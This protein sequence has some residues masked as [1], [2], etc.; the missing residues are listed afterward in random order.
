MKINV[1]APVD[2]EIGKI[3]DLKDGVF[4]EKMLGDGFYIRAKKTQKHFFA[5]VE[6]GKVSLIT[7]T[8]HAFFFEINPQISVLM[9]I[10]LDTVKLEGKPFTQKVNVLD[11]ISTSTNIVDVDIDYIN[12]SGLDHVCPITLNVD[13]SSLGTFEFKMVAKLKNVKQG[14]LVGWF[15]TVENS[16]VSKEVDT[17]T[18]AKSFFLKDGKYDK[19][20]KS[21]NKLVGTK[22]NYS[23]VYN[24]MTRLRFKIQNKNI[25]KI[26]E[27]K[28]IAEVRGIVWNGN[29]LQ[30]I[31]G[32]DVYK[33]KEAVEKNNQI[34]LG[35]FELQAKQ[36][37]S[38]GKA[39]MAMFAG[40]MT[41]MIPLFIGTGII[42]AIIGL[43]QLGP[44]PMI[45][46]ADFFPSENGAPAILEL[47]I[48]WGI[49][50]VI[51]KA[52][53]A[54]MGVAI[55]VSASKYFK[56]DMVFGAGIG[57][58]I[59]APMMFSNGGP[60]SIGEEWVLFDFG[61]IVTPTEDNIALAAVANKISKWTVTSAGI[62]IFAVI[63]IIYLAAVVDR[64]V[65]SWVHPLLELTI[66]PLIVVLV[67][68]GIG[69]FLFIP[70]WNIFEGMFGTAMYYISQ[71][72][73]GIGV[74]LFASIYQL[75][76]VFGIHIAIAMIAQIQSLTAYGYGDFMFAISIAVWAQVGALI[77]VILMTKN[78]K[79]KRQAIGLIP[80]GVLGVT[81]PILYGI[82]LPK[83]RPLI[84]G[85]IAA[86]VAAAFAGIMGVTTRVST[87]L[88]IFEVI[89][90]FQLSPLDPT[91][92]LGILTGQLSTTM[93][94]IW[95]IVACL[96]SVGGALL[97]CMLM[98]KERKTEKQGI[99]IITS[100]IIKLLSLNNP[101]LKQSLIEKAKEL[102]APLTKEEIEFIKAQEKIIQELNKL[103]SAKEA[104]NTKE[105]SIKEKLMSKG[106]EL[107]K[108]EKESNIIKAEN[109]MNKL[110]AINN[111]A[112]R[113]EFDRLIKDKKASLDTEKM[114]KLI[115]SKMKMI[116][117]WIADVE[118]IS[119]SEILKSEKLL[120]NFRNALDV[121]RISYGINEEL[122]EM[123]LSENINQLKNENKTA[124]QLARA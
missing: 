36:K 19:L 65:R 100:K 89:G 123:N 71:L 120:N 76:V 41:K 25:V 114:N 97:L 112:K 121:M 78:A 67:S 81:E 1:Y 51:G 55:A 44:M 63:A 50:F 3:E 103:Q 54:S 58:I 116:N 21:I 106:A 15:E 73:F 34:A 45:S 91:G 6:S 57:I 22:G 111:D 94:G 7:E 101:E 118:K 104:L 110:N 8:K 93:N 29:E 24:C 66:R 96:I 30:I 18:D 90:Y 72:P 122:P 31:I 9:H 47:G 20:A 2:G 33:L 88:G 95:Y 26:D 32:Q 75:S 69:M 87:G 115:A 28:A 84:A 12:Q 92:E 10:G 37:L 56:L 39:F 61:D 27:I 53:M 13:D 109:I 4:S 38:P 83:K 102:D 105:F 108:S 64:W 62:K 42:Q 14:E 49:L 40:I 17:K 124:K 5:P 117:K 46:F 113:A 85:S 68:C 79:L 99:S 98:Y 77:G 43:L 16:K 60:S 119:S 23:D 70:L 59:C 74:G 86:A 107:I 82:N 35:D 80:V 11:S 48:G 52:M